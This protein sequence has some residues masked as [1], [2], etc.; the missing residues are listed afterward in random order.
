MAIAWSDHFKKVYKKKPPE[1]QAAIQKCLRKLASD[2]NLPGLN[3]HRVK[4]T[5]GVWEAYIDD[6]NRITFHYDDRGIVLRNN[7]NHDILTRRP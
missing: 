7:C 4:G 1:M 2:I 3:V 6:G 5:N